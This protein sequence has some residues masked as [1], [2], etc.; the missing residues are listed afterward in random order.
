MR[1]YRNLHLRMEAHFATANVS[2]AVVIRESDG[3]LGYE[4]TRV[5]E[6]SLRFPLLFNYY[7]SDQAS[8]FLG[9]SLV[10]VTRSETKHLELPTALPYREN[11]SDFDLAITTGLNVNLHPRVSATAWIARHLNHYYIE[12]PDAFFSPR[13][14]TIGLSLSFRLS[15]L[16]KSE[17]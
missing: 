11:R 15:Q 17:E 8:A 1:L 10:L 3:T 14:V 6:Q 9:A 16:V 4:R 2:G 12:R 7:A 5:H 13:L